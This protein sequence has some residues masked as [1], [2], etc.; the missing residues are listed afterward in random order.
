MLQLPSLQSARYFLI[1]TLPALNDLGSV[2]PMGITDLLEH[3]LDHKVWRE[4]METLVL[5]DD[6]LQRE[7]FLAG[8][9]EKVETTVLTEQQARGEAP[10]PEVLISP[11][12][13]E[14]TNAVES[15]LLWENYFRYAHKV[16]RTRGSRFLT[17]WVEFEVTL[18]NTLAAARAQRLGLDETDYLVAPDLTDEDE[19][20]SLVLNEWESATTP[21]LGARAV[22]RARWAWIDRH[23]A[24]FSFYTDEL[25]VY[26]ARVMLLDQWL[27]SAKADEGVA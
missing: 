3:V 27:R 10:L 24:W 19:D 23:D 15:D 25:L 7:S 6:L 21:L 1:S 17:Q 22:I 11:V 14:G 13:H 12:E 26:A 8:D 9:I 5:Q 18:R 2:P 20:V 16:G 4:L